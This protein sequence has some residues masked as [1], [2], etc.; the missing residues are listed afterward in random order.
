MRHSYTYLPYLRNLYSR[1]VV[2][3]EGNVRPKRSFDSP[4]N[5]NA[6]QTSSFATC[7]WRW[8]PI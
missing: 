5:C 4:G 7:D 1:R 3:Y 2:N 6:V 8:L